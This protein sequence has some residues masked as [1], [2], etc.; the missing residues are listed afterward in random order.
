MVRGRRLYSAGPPVAGRLVASTP[1][2]G[3]RS[4][5]PRLL[6]GWPRGRACWSETG[7]T[8]LDSRT[9]T[10]SPRLPVQPGYDTG[11]SARYLAGVSEVRR[12]ELATAQSDRGPTQE[13]N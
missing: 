8:R 10:A 5:L 4:S 7:A 13:S 9:P 3:W 6:P 12:P 11:R 2:E 1:A